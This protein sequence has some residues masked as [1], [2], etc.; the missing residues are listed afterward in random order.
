MKKMKSTSYL[1]NVSRG[2]VVN[3]EDLFLA[4]TQGV[5]KGAAA[6]VFLQEPCNSHPLFALDN[7]IPT[8]HIAG[9]TEGAISNIGEQCVYN[10]IEHVIHQRKPKN[11]M[12]GL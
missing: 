6:D 7:F 8:A 11:I 4:L 3:E 1:I 12:N 10:I 5:I 2:G 9:Y